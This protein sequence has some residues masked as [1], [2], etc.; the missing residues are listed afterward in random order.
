MFR[1]W[2]FFL[3]LATAS[4]GVR[5]DILESSET[6]DRFRV[7]NSGWLSSIAGTESKH[8]ESP[9]A[10]T[11]KNNMVYFI[12]DRLMG[13]YAYDMVSQGASSLKSVYAKL[14]R[15]PARLFLSDDND[16]FVIDSFGSQVL[17]YDLMGNFLTRYSNPSNLNSP[18]GMCLNPLNQNILIADSF[19]SH[20]VEFS[21]T[22]QAIQLHDLKGAG[23]RQAGN[24][25]T[26]MACGVNAVFVVSKFTPDINVFSYSGKFLHKIPRSEARIPTA[27]AVDQFDRVYLSDDFDDQIKIYDTT[28]LIARFGGSGSGPL[29][30]RGIKDLWI[31]ANQL[32][33]ADNMNRRI[34]VFFIN[35]LTPAG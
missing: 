18:V 29:N 33:V 14:S 2:V 6:I 8:I 1:S 13:L 27:I 20:I 9:V 16:L 11:A 4:M 25:I 5:S 10:I 31:D 7:I 19:Y 34:Q 21:L 22:G 30:F 17:R 26:S 32:Y 15:N 28:G 35:P 3:C 23:E 24:H 12:D